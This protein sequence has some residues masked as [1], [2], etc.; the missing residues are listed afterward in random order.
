MALMHCL[1][2]RLRAFKTSQEPRARGHDAS[3]GLVYLPAH[4]NHGIGGACTGMPHP[5]P[6]GGDD[7]ES[8][9]AAQAQVERTGEEVCVNRSDS[10]G[11]AG[12][13]GGQEMGA[14]AGGVAVDAGD[15]GDGFGLGD[16]SEDEQTWCTLWMLYVKSIC[17]MVHDDRY[18]LVAAPAM[19]LLERALLSADV[20]VPY[21]HAWRDCY[22][23]IIFPIV[24]AKFKSAGPASAGSAPSAAEALCLSTLLLLCKSFRNNLETIIHL[25]ELHMVWLKLLGL[26][27]ALKYRIVAKQ[28]DAVSN[29]IVLVLK[30]MLHAMHSD[31][32]FKQVQ[33]A[34]GQDMWALTST[35]IDAFCP[36]LKMEL[37]TTSPAQA[38]AGAHA[39]GAPEAGLL[40][41]RAPDSAGEAAAESCA[42]GPPLAGQRSASG[43]SAAGALHAHGDAVGTSGQEAGGSG[44]PNTGNSVG[45]SVPCAANAGGSSS[46]DASRA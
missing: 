22:N 25:P 1:F 44:G 27:E 34:S 30:E 37:M 6:A 32:T 16:S 35:V 43:S 46:D 28:R 39:G 12:A 26:I 17:R 33:Q 21:A 45:A 29:D 40:M 42:V 13:S 3:R 9:A 41:P 38:P 36:D 23:Q 8:A 18:S 24:Q 20:A 2:L 31:K 11:G 19:H 7:A 15:E 4:S 5:P 10:V 14:W